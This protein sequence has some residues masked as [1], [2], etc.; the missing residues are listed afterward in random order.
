MN[1]KIKRNFVLIHK[2]TTE[3]KG[4]IA[5]FVSILIGIILGSC[6]YNSPDFS[7]KNKL[8]S[9]FV[10]FNTEITDKTHIEIFSGLVLSG[11]I[12][13]VLMFF[14]GGNIFGKELSLLVTSIK[15]SGIGALI[16]FLYN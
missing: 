16:A 9:L 5:S 6:I 4:I 2:I 1:N 7:L 12:Y 3:K 8:L 14:C 11:L 13:Y 10:S 15:A